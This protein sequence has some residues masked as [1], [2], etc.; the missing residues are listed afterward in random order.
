[1]VTL[2]ISGNIAQG[3]IRIGMVRVEEPQQLEVGMVMVEAIFL[4]D[5]V[6]KIVVIT[7]FTRQANWLE[8]LEYSPLRSIVR[9]ATDPIVLFLGGQR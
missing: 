8:L 9:H 3:R 1:M 4:E 7:C 5:V 2:G 6:A